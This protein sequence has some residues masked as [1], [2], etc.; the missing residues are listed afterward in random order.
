MVSRW[1]L[2]CSRESDAQAMH[3]G[4][5]SSSIDVA[6]QIK[7]ERFPLEKSTICIDLAPSAT[8]D[9]RRQFVASE[10]S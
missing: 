1:P 2:D 5:M 10:A 6:T 9:L 3:D 7:I 8:R 4:L